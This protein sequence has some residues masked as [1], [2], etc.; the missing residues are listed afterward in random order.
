MYMENEA[1]EYHPQYGPAYKEIILR[2][3]LE[4]PQSA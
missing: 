3:S 4:N 1:N 2:A